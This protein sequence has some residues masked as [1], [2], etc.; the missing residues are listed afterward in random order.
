MTARHTILGGKVHLYKRPDAR[1]WQ[2]STTVGGVRFRDSTKKDE[3]S[4][5]EDAAEEWYLELRS[6]FKR[7]ELGELKQVNKEKTFREVAELFLREFKALTEGHRSPIYVGGHERRVKKHLNPFMGDKPISQITSGLVQEY[8][9]HR[10]EQCKAAGGKAPARNTIHQEIV[11]IRQVLKTALRHQWIAGLPDL[12]E[13]Y[14]LNTKV[15]H[16][17]WFSPEEYRALYT[18]TQAMAK[19]PP[20]RRYAREYAQLHDFILFMANTGL[21]PDEAARL[22]Y[23]D[24]SV[25]D[26]DRSGETI[27][28]IECRGKRGYGPCK[29]T[30]NAV[31][32]FRRL[33]KRNQPQPTD[34]IFPSLQRDLFNRILEKLKLKYDR[35]GRPRTFYS[36]RH[37]YISFRL[38]EGAN[39]LQIAWNC[40]TS[41]DM[42][43]KYYAAHIKTRL[44]AS[45][46]NVRSGATTESGKPGV[47][48]ANDNA[49]EGEELAA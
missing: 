17:A 25:V 11:V 19:K 30:A 14:R 23:R 1:F 3:L 5:A 47:I 37:T 9:V 28:V 18:E 44:D 2:C 41:V 43:E 22:E 34:R 20:H 46:I 38:L 15:S 10:V 13:P 12:S 40:R 6:K 45:A 16:R 4:Q 49:E 36:L 35:E 31:P 32:I 48:A 7:G 39:V 42:I 24:V 27:L 26:D 21:R 29:S 33:Q 8:R